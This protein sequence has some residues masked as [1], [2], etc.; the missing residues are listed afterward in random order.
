MQ[1]CGTDGVTYDNVCRLRTLSA[2]ARVD[3]YGVCQN[4][5]GSTPNNLCER[6]SI[7]G[8]C[9]YNSSNCNFLV[10]PEEGCCPLCGE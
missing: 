9:A 3:F 1:V 6:V 2:N 4:G 5:P 8:W 7:S 10:E